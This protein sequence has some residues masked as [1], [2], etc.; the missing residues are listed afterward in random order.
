MDRRKSPTS[1]GPPLMPCGDTCRG[2]ADAERHPPPNGRCTA[3]IIP[4]SPED[5]VACPN[6]TP[7]EGG[8]HDDGCT[9]MVPM[10]RWQKGGDSKGGVPVLCASQLLGHKQTLQPPTGD[11]AVETG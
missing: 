1:S 8:R 10:H 6:I 2:H 11:T 5:D 7:G 9:T 4:Q 3:E